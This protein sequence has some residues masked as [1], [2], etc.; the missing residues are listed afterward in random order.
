M[1]ER[2][3]PLGA[4][5]AEA[6]NE[7]KDHIDGKIVLSSRI[8][9]VPDNINVKQIRIKYGLTQNE[10]ANHFGFTLNSVK[11][12]E[13]GRRNPERAARILLAIIDKE[14]HVVERVLDS[15]E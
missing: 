4:E 15:F 1:A 12:W 11:D 14:P 6:L 7:M 10:F 5:I 3:T 8:I 2:L 13:Q 9:N